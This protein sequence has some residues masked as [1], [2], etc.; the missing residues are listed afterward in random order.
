MDTTAFIQRFENATAELAGARASL[1][2]ELRDLAR[3]SSDWELP[4]TRLQSLQAPIDELF[5]ALDV[6]QRAAIEAVRTRVEQTHQQ[7]DSAISELLEAAQTR[8]SEFEQQLEDATEQLGVDR[9][10]FAASVEEFRANFATAL[11]ALEA[12]ANE[13]TTTLGQLE[14]AML[15]HA[16]ELASELMPKLVAAVDEFSGVVEGTMKSNIEAQFTSSAERVNESFAAAA[17]DIT[18]AF[19]GALDKLEQAADALKAHVTE[20]LKRELEEGV[21]KLVDDATR[22]LSEEVVEGVVIS[23]TGVAVTSA[24][25]PYLPALIVIKRTT[26]VIKHGLELLKKVTT[27]GIG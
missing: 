27:L 5:V 20:S 16:S 2:E 12:A 23:Q 11:V 18:Q 6:T 1:S 26:D 13:T 8:A 25:S 21:E 19:T 24:M 17:S 7:L 4:V 14:D 22:K 10:R 3:E 15:G 9:E